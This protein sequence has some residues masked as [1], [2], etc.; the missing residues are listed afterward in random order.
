MPAKKKP[1]ISGAPKVPANFPRPLHNR[2]IVSVEKPETQTAGGI[3]IPDV[4]AEQ[5]NRGYI[6][7]VGPRVEDP[8]VQVGKIAVYGEYC[9][10]DID[11]DGRDY[12]IMRE[13][14]V[15]FIL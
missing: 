14:D 9:G 7:A 6:M 13:S 15:L 1:L 12:L 8:A 3:I 5:Q 4:A 10:T 11:H 2:I